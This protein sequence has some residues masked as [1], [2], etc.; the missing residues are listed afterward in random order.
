TNRDFRYGPASAPVTAPP[1]SPSRRVSSFK[2]RST[3][4]YGLMAVL[5]A[6][7]GACATPYFSGWSSDRATQRHRH[8]VTPALMPPLSVRCSRSRRMPREPLDTRHGL[9]EQGPCQVAF[10]ELQGEVPG[11]SDE[12]PARLEQPLLQTRLRPALDGERQGEPPHEIAE[13]G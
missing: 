13:I 12:A 5:L 3:L 9:L 10:G 1:S 2:A 11:M 4:P 8:C 7:P 6:K